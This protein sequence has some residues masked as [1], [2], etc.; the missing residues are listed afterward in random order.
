MKITVSQDVQ[1]KISR[2]EMKRIAIQ[3][4]KEEYGLENDCYIE[5]GQ[6]CNDHAVYGHNIE[7]ER[8]VLYEATEKQLRAWELL[9]EI[10]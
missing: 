2:P 4:I 1:V 3:Y 7:Y 6:I 10:G 5:D 8:V 9:K